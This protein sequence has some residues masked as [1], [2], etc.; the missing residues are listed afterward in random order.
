MIV[1]YSNKAKIHF[2]NEYY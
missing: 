2:L 1:E